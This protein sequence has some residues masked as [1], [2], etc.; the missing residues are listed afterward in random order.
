MKIIKWYIF[1]IFLCSLTIVSE[2]QTSFVDSDL[3]TRACPGGVCSP[4]SAGFCPSSFICPPNGTNGGGGTGSS[5]ICAN[6]CCV[7]AQ[8][9]NVSNT[10]NVA[11]ENVSG[12]LTV[13]GSV[14]V[15]GSL[16]VEGESDF[17]GDVCAEQNLTVGD[18][19]TIGGDATV[20][21]SLNVND[22]AFINGLL[23]IN[24]NEIV[25][26]SITVT[27]NE[28][29][30]GT[31]TVGT[32]G[33]INGLLIAAGGLSVFNGET[34]NNGGLV[35][36]SG[37]ANISGDVVING[38][39][40]VDD[41][42]VLGNLTVDE[43]AFF[44]GC[45]TT[46]NGT[47]TTNGP[48][49]M[50]KGLNIVS[51]NE[52]IQT[53]DLTLNVG[54]LTVGGQSIFNGPVTANNGATINNGLTVFG[55]QTIATGNL[56][57]ATC[58]NAT[59]GN[60]LNVTNQI[61]SP[62]AATLFSL[63]LTDTTNSTSPSTG[64][65]VVNGGVGIAQ[66]LWMGDSIFFQQVIREGGTPSP[67]NY[68]EET[69]FDMTFEYSTSTTTVAIQVVRIGNL[70]NLLIP[71]MFFDPSAAPDTVHSITQMP[72]RFR[73]FCIVRGA[74]STVVNDESQLGEYEVN[75]DGNIIIGLPGAALGP[76][77][78]ASAITVQV[79]INTITYNRLS[80]GCPPAL[81]A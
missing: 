71:T 66:D 40:T 63:L 46:V 64:T 80:C 38:T 23:T 15:G 47:L 11:C 76:Q 21:G 5:G 58:G 54:N 73:P 18:N 68:Y 10:V 51:G 69:C 37:G 3:V 55:G 41:L 45:N 43:N 79:D 49:I 48:V 61:T 8:T 39:Q 22:G 20:S 19:A 70:V 36:L 62:S 34:I 27:G 16:I 72:V 2:A 65:L 29:I 13:G 60:A 26:G 28:T 42:E 35:I 4:C 14:L 33:T 44:N 6:F 53:G 31:I 67:F 56:T 17:K 32:T 24:G 52:V 81:V 9:L 30:G 7:N 50:N 77:P 25:N 78:F 59:I 1:L 74:A 12:N 57:I 75:P